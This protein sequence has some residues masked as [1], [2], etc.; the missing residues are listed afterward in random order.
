MKRFYILMVVLLCTTSLF[1]EINWVED[2]KMTTEVADAYTTYLTIDMRQWQDVS[3]LIKNV[4]VANGITV[5]VLGYTNFNGHIAEPISSTDWDAEQ[6]LTAGQIGK[7]KFTTNWA[8]IV[9]QAKNTVG[10]SA[11]D[12][13]I[14]W[15]AR[16]E[17]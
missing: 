16:K 9:I 10:A 4:D 12:I 8:K 14:E 13:L 5:Q 1:C 3:V 6:A 2:E 11:G 15:I 17:D 7:L